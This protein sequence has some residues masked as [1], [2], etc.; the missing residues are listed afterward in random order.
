MKPNRS[1]L[2][3]F[4]GVLFLLVGSGFYLLQKA[5]DDLASDFIVKENF[6]QALIL[7]QSLNENV[8]RSRSFVS[9]NYDSMVA[10]SELN[11]HASD[12]LRRLSTTMIED[13]PELPVQL[14]SYFRLWNEKKMAIED[15]KAKHSV[16]RN[17]LKYLS[18]LELQAEG[19]EVEHQAHQLL[20]SVL[21]F[22]L[23]PTPNHEKQVVHNLGILMKAPGQKKTSTAE[24]VDSLALHTK[25]ILRSLR[26]RET[27]EKIILSRQVPEA[28]ARAE[29]LYHSWSTQNSRN[30]T[31]IKLLLGTVCVIL[32]VALISFFRRLQMASAELTVLNR[33]LELKVTKRTEELSHTL[34][35]LAQKQQVLV[36]A[37]KMSALGEMAGGVAHEINTPLAVIQMRSEQVQDMINDGDFDQGFLTEALESIR[38][39]SFRIA[40]IV[41]GLRMFS[42]NGER[43]PLQPVALGK[44]IDDTFSF[45][46][47]RFTNNG[48][49]LEI[50]DESGA[51][52]LLIPCRPTE[53]SQVLLNLFNNSYDATQSSQ[54]KWVQIHLVDLRESV[55]LSVTDS[56]AGISPL[57]R[58]KI[59]QPFFTTKEVGKGTGL[60]LSVSQ[61]IA[62]A[63]G[64]SLRLDENSP[65]TR[66]VLTL[67]KDRSEQFRPAA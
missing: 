28:L 65:H 57:I 1:S 21:S 41:N 62:H 42:R 17:S 67:P 51:G 18:T 38:E 54:D 58:E 5:E 32:I 56:G 20:F 45:C 44:V 61:G 15:F 35:E 2:L 25:I 27:S 40:K 36:Q 43:D 66:F 48:V 16:L 52:S 6:R 39:T 13:L 9:E 3:A 53:I 49:R 63:H 50:V 46:R 11:D 64:G 37:S 19:T 10:D 30:S 31:Y 55:E 59:M 26:D 22:N 12:E 34:Q 14:E 47:E 60:G 4:L 24:F 29:N 23:S 7:D 8:L 33:D